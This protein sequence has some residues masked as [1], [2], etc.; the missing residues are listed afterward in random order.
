M[1]TVRTEY[2]ADELCKRMIWALDVVHHDILGHDKTPPLNRAGVDAKMVE[3]LEKVTNLVRKFEDSFIKT[4][5]NDAVKIQGEAQKN[6]AIAK[7]AEQI[8]DKIEDVLEDIRNEEYQDMRKGN[9]LRRLA[10]HLRGKV[11]KVG[12]QLHRLEGG[13]AKGTK[14][15]RLQKRFL[16]AAKKAKNN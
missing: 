13:L 7:Q 9:F 2:S 12:R 11:K 15:S 6:P 10:N 5:Y 3:D 14:D 8:L 4:I 16:A 1:A